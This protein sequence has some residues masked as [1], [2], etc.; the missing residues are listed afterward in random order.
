MVDSGFEF[1]LL[2]W[3]KHLYNIEVPFNLILSNQ[4]LIEQNNLKY[5]D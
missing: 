3:I 2:L 5:E 1:V 4:F